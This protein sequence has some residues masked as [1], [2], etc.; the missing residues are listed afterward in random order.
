MKLYETNIQIAALIEQLQPDPETGEIP[1]NT[2]DVIEQL[3]GLEAERGEIIQWIAKEALNARAE[4]A[5]IKAEEDRLCAV[6][7]S[8]EKLTERLIGILDREC[9]G[10]NTDLG[11]AK[12]QHRK[13][14]KTEITDQ[15]EAVIWLEES[16]YDEAIRYA[17]PTVDKT[18]IKALFKQGI[19][20]PGTEIV[21]SVSV[22][23]R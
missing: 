18:E 3:H 2:D 7:K 20:V 16:G 6:R 9:G 12:L 8:K 15:E 1:A 21:D 11:I 23:L 13:T 19:K 22:S 5:A 14:Q 10:E 4:C 17:L